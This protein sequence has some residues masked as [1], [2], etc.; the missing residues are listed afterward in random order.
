M[1]TRMPL[2][3]DIKAQVSIYFVQAARPV[4]RVRAAGKLR[5]TTSELSPHP[6]RL[7]Y[8]VVVRESKVELSPV[9][10]SKFLSDG[11]IGGTV[12]FVGLEGILSADGERD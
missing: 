5:A 10:D 8:M 12:G 4:R 2:L 7:L 3:M 6:D 9:Y 1:S 11:C